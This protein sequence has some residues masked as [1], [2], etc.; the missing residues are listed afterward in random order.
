[1]YAV[2]LLSL[3]KNFSII[4]KS[5][6]IIRD[7]YIPESN[8]FLCLL[9]VRNM[10]ISSFFKCL[11]ISYLI[12]IL[13]FKNGSSIISIIIDEASVTPQLNQ[14]SPMLPVPIKI[15]LKILNTQ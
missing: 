4:K 11:I 15:F 10:W 14:K 2:I 3:T 5:I 6:F 7:N 8:Y 1:M 13:L 9:S 12:C